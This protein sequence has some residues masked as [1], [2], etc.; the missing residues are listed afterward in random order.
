MLQACYEARLQ[1]L[2]LLQTST[3]GIFVFRRDFWTAAQSPMT[4]PMRITQETFDAAVCENMEEFGMEEE[5]A[6]SDAVEQF[7]VQGVDLSNIVQSTSTEKAVHP[8]CTWVCLAPF[9]V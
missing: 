6:V 2:L 3:L 5:E 9:P 7:S 4:K 8:V 1:F